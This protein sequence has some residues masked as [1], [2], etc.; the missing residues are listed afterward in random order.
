MF[1]AVVYIAAA[2][3]FAII[4]I[5]LVSLSAWLLLTVMRMIRWKREIRRAQ[6]EAYQEMHDEQGQ[7]LPPVSRGICQKCGRYF[8]QIYYLPDGT[9]VCEECYQADRFVPGAKEQSM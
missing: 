1:K 9:G 5:V 3:A 2:L 7:R 8:E 4:L 6:Q